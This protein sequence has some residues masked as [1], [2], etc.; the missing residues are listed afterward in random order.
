[1]GEQLTHF[2]YFVVVVARRAREHRTILRHEMIVEMFPGRLLQLRCCIFFHSFSNILRDGVRSLSSWWRVRARAHIQN[3]RNHGNALL[4]S[5]TSMV[6]TACGVPL[7]TQSL[8]KKAVGRIVRSK[9]PP[10]AEACG[11][12]DCMP[13]FLLYEAGGSSLSSVAALRVSW[14]C[15]RPTT[16]PVVPSRC[17]WLDANRTQRGVSEGGAWLL[18]LLLLLLASLALPAC[19]LERACGAG[20]VCAGT[21]GGGRHPCGAMAGGDAPSCDVAGAGA[22]GAVFT[23]T[24]LVCCG[25]QSAA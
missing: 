5:H 10:V 16:V 18:L 21:N 4:A 8:Y 19:G 2:T 7:Y 3:A 23:S 11:P 9:T 25:T 6:Y 1:M 24:T 17:P 20:A 15:R 14:D 22:S 13:S 12:Y